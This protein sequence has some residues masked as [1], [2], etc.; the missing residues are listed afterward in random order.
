MTDDAHAVQEIPTRTSRYLLRRD[1]IVVQR[2]VSSRVQ[3]L[4]D[5]RENVAAYAALAGGKKR[6]GLIDLRMPAPSERGVREYYAGPEATRVCAALALL[7]PS[8]A[9][10]IIGNL[11]LAIQ[12]PTFPTRLFN[13]ELDAIA[14][15]LKIAPAVGAHTEVP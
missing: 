7:V 12:A 10:R 13:T 14:W 9:A 6:L 4:E 1:G 11:F 8:A 3:T 5:A 2:L 15:L